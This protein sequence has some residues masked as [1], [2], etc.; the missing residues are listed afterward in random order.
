MLDLFV[1]FGALVAHGTR[2]RPLTEA[3]LIGCLWVKTVGPE[4]CSLAFGKLG[5]RGFR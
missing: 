5:Y 4:I 2:S 1:E 3:I